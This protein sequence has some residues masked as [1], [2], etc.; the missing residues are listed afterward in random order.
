MSS[1]AVGR[2]IELCLATIRDTGMGRPLAGTGY[3]TTR[4]ISFCVGEQ[5]A[6]VR[7]V[8]D[9]GIA[10][11]PP[12][13]ADDVEF[14]DDMDYLRSLAEAMFDYGYGGT[15]RSPQLPCETVEQRLRASMSCTAVA[16]CFGGW[17]SFEDMWEAA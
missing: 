8:S 9:I 6:A 14:D 16:A 7:P 3:P 11:P 17:K 5:G 1:W 10:L 12:S 2:V 13:G 15:D 4:R